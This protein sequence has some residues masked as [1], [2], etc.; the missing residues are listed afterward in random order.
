MTNLAISSTFL[1]GSCAH[2][3]I[4]GLDVA[5]QGK[6]LAKCGRCQTFMYCSPKCQTAD[7][8]QH[9]KVCASFAD[10]LK[11]AIASCKK[12]FVEKVRADYHAQFS[13]E[14]V[15]AKLQALGFTASP[16][17]LEG[18][19]SKVEEAVN[20]AIDQVIG[21]FEEDLSK[22]TAEEG[23]K[24]TRNQERPTDLAQKREIVISYRDISASVFPDIAVTYSQRIQSIMAQALKDIDRDMSQKPATTPPPQE[25]AD[26]KKSAQEACTQCATKAADLEKMGKTLMKCAK[27]VTAMY[28]SRECQVAHWPAH[29]QA[30]K[31]Q[32]AKETSKQT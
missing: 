18:Y 11:G 5:S 10:P 22:K 4:S 12:H 16:A 2:C 19:E 15:G 29:K 27:C 21:S 6:T 26:Q 25:S 32:S 1:S 30:C 17:W 7:W 14:A 28:C 23:K 20:S 31:L 24:Q 13:K 3:K 8:P 9:K